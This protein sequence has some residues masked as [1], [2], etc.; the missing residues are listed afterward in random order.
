M[1]VNGPKVMTTTAVTTVTSSSKA[2]LNPNHFLQMGLEVRAKHFMETKVA[3]QDPMVCHLSA[4]TWTGCQ[5]VQRVLC[6]LVRVRLMTPIS[7]RRCEL[8]QKTPTVLCAPTA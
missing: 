7:Q 1:L 6:K 4:N 3:T 5:V 8:M 2:R